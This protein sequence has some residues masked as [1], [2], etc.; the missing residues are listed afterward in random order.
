MNYHSTISDEAFGT[1]R[2]DSDHAPLSLLHRNT[3]N[4]VYSMRGSQIVG[5]SETNINQFKFDSQPKSV[6]PLPKHSV[7]HLTNTSRPI[8]SW[9]T[10]KIFDKR[11]IVYERPEPKLKVFSISQPFERV[12]E[13]TPSPRPPPKLQVYAINKKGNDMFL[14]ENFGRRHEKVEY[15]FGASPTPRPTKPY[16][17]PLE[18][19]PLHGARS[20]RNYQVPSSNRSTVYMSDSN[21]SQAGYSYR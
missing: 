17:E 9:N 14:F 19:N 7:Y 15:K 2:T 16:V 18:L 21:R 10:I 5:I 1:H 13:A 11:R 8:E 20:P 3:A 4:Q 6:A 12:L